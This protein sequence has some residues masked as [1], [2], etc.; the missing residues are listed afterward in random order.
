MIYESRIV[1][2]NPEISVKNIKNNNARKPITRLHIYASND[3][4]DSK[5]ASH[6]PPAVF[7]TP[8]RKSRSVPR[9]GKHKYICIPKY[10][11]IAK[12]YQ[13]HIRIITTIRYL[14]KAT[15]IFPNPRR[16]YGGKH[17]IHETLKLR[18]DFFS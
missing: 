6:A 15:N 18:R 10:D 17:K 9:K 7:T 12:I 8:L 16:M 3:L 2:S 5:I 13:S 14:L 11:Y 4:F 1:I